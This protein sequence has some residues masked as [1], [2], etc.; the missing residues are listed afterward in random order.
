[1]PL[2][3][4]ERQLRMAAEL[5]WRDAAVVTVVH[6]GVEQESLG[7]ALFRTA[8]GQGGILQNDI[9]LFVI[10]KTIRHHADVHSDKV[11]LEIA[12]IQRLPKLDTLHHLTKRKQAWICAEAIVNEVAT[13][14][15]Q[16]EDQAVDGQC[17][18]LLVMGSKLAG[19]WL[20]TGTRDAAENDDLDVI[21]FGPLAT[22][23]PCA[24]TWFVATM[25]EVAPKATSTT[26][27]F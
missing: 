18:Y 3:L 25:K 26:H 11:V 23:N 24:A 9:P 7:T 20:P 27:E 8:S 15:G 22:R 1:M 16:V 21:V 6:F 12:Q 2:V 13:L 4:L 5:K 19:S 14:M 17:C 10:A